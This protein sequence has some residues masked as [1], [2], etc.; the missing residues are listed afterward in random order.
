MKRKYKNAAQ[1]FL[2]YI[3]AAAIMLTSIIPATAV[4]ADAVQN[5]PNE[6]YIRFASEL[7]KHNVNSVVLTS[8][9]MMSNAVTSDGTEVWRFTGSGNWPYVYIDLSDS[10]AN[11]YDDGSEYDIEI[12][13]NDTNTGYCII[14][15]DAVKWGKQIGY[16]IYATASNVWKTAKFTLD[17][18]AFKGGV[19]EKGDLMLSF[20]EKGTSYPTTQSPVDIASIKVTR[21]PNANPI[22]AESYI[23]TYGNAFEYYKDEK[24]VHNE[25]RNTTKKK[26]TVD[27]TYKLV[28]KELKDIVFSKTESMTIPSNSTA[29]SDVNIEADRCG[30]Y[31]WYV[32]IK[33]EDGSINSVFKED[34]IG[35]IK[36]DPNGI[37]AETQGIATHA[38]R[39]RS[40][41]SHNLVELVAMANFG[42]I[43]QDMEDTR[44]EF[45]ERVLGD[46]Y[47]H[48]AFRNTR[49]LEHAKEKGLKVLGQ[50]KGAHAW[51]QGKG[52][53]SGSTNSMPNTEASHAR[54]EEYATALV[55]NLAPYIDYWEVWNEP[56]VKA[57]NDNGGK[58]EDLVKI[59]KTARKVVD[60]YDPGSPTIGMSITHLDGTGLEWRDPLL[61]GGIVDGDNGMNAMAVHPYHFAKSPE[62]YN[63][64]S[65]IEEY[66]DKALE[67]ANKTGI[68]EMPVFITE[69][70]YSPNLSHIGDE[71]G[72]NWPIRSSIIYKAHGVGNYLFYYVMEEKGVIDYDG[73]DRYGIITTVVK[74]EYNIEGKLGVV[75]ERYVAFTAMNYVLGGNIEP[76]G[77]WECDN[78]VYLNRFKSDKFNKNVLAMWR[79][80]DAAS[81]TLDLGVDTVDYYDRYGN[82][83]VVYGRDG[84][85][86]FILDGRPS[87]IVGNFNKNRVVNY[88]P[89]VE[90]SNLNMEVPQYDKAPLTVTTDASGD[91]EAVFTT[92]GEKAESV[93][94]KLENG[95]ATFNVPGNGEVGDKSFVDVSVYENGRQIA[96]NQIPMTIVNAVDTE[97]TFELIDSSNL[98]NWNGKLLVTN[99]CLEADATGYIEFS[100]PA[101]FK[102]LGKI[103]IGLVENLSTKEVVFN[104]PNL[105]D[106]GMKT[107]SYKLVNENLQTEPTEFSLVNNFSV[108]V[109]AKAEV[110]IDGIISEGEWT[111]NNK[112]TAAAPSNFIPHPNK[113]SDYYDPAPCETPE[114]KSANA[115]VMWDEEYLY[116][117]TEVIDD[118]Y[119]QNET[120][121]NSWKTDGIQFGV[122]AD[123]GEVDFFAIGATNTNFHEYTLALS[124]D[125]S[126][127]EVYKSRTQDDRTQIGM[128]DVEAK[129]R[130]SGN[131]TT[132]EWAIPWDEMVGIEGWHPT[133]GAVLKFSMLWNENDGGGRKGW[134][135]FASG[136]GT[137][138]DNRLFTTL[139]LVK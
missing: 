83:E 60:K 120:V 126:K 20:A 89:L 134:I 38:S 105:S 65:N 33:N 93:K 110:V 79:D 82:K 43:R 47:Y 50:I 29:T 106:R 28:D 136:I 94:V 19:D 72:I 31:T 128:V 40:D 42:M 76:D 61:E 113:K 103:D 127:V 78:D 139:K 102:A 23:D 100:E 71:N 36:T 27:V 132:Y 54:F 51:Y 49:P 15:Y 117:A 39:Y 8:D 77:Y 95:T 30:M 99:N 107:L 129:A 34:D 68:E 2:T 85:F 111:A 90:Y 91:C 124:A 41:A 4:A 74:P 16:E 121:Q 81:V 56:N 67:Y 75:K 17:N 116:M 58:P 45:L 96:F 123:I 12:T 13:Y 92:H 133:A 87:Y 119:F 32:E 135:E 1:R 57:F 104:I 7:Q 64:V 3:C 84:K 18:A 69:Y 125:G 21:R 70:G 130:R 63:I 86:T 114:D 5:N 37:Q 98:E 112:L 55:K 6:A 10:L 66:R 138:K 44:W 26:Q 24:I 52:T 46:M 9:S 80:G 53:M 118:V 62:G 11:S 25:I 108:A 22:L 88:A 122:Y 97:L 48:G 35:I 137:S 109:E 73:E 14:W 131:I 101:E 115:L 59:T